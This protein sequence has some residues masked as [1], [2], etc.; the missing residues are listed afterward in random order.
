MKEMFIL[1]SSSI[2]IAHMTM[3]FKS[4]QVFSLKKNS[5]QFIPMFIFFLKRIFEII[6]V[7]KL[8]FNHFIHFLSNRKNKAVKYG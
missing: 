7:D 5:K 1:F 8:V 3:L 2:S 6:H 4:I